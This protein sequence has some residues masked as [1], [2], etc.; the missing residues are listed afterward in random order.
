MFSLYDLLNS[1]RNMD[2]ANLDYKLNQLKLAEKSDLRMLN[3]AQQRF[4]AKY[5]VYD[6]IK[7]TKVITYK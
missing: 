7:I 3:S 6:N 4:T 1:K 2:K 5:G